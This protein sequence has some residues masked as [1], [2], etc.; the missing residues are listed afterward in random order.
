MSAP[1]TKTLALTGATGFIG[2]ALIR[3]LTARGWRVRALVRS[4]SQERFRGGPGTE[5]VTGD[6]ADTGALERLVAGA[7][8]VVH[9]AAAVRGW[10]TR[11][12]ETNVEGT[13]RLVRAASRQRRAPRLVLLSSLAAREPHL[14][15]YAA[16]KRAA[17][18]VLAQHA[19]DMPWTILRPPAVYGPGDREL[20]PLFTWMARGLAP[21]L[22]S[23]EARFSL[24]YVQDLADCIVHLVEEDLSP[25]TTHEVHDGHRGGYGWTELIGV[26]ERLSGRRAVRIRVPAPLASSVAALNLIAKRALGYAPMLTPGKIRELTHPDWVCDDRPLSATTTW[27]PAIS[28]E[29]GLRRT[30]VQPTLPP[31]RRSPGSNDE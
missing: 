25:G 12:Q 2:G 15:P 1:S 7:D 11:F 16:S 22:G 13:R 4:T 5:M 14:S 31:F 21:V 29:E 10:G 3:L 9:A 26:I 23:P 8:A 18:D 27:R 24:L 30:L 19:G 6:L 20:L 17:E 28:L